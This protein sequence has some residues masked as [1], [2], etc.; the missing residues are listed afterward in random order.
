LAQRD[1]AQVLADARDT[2]DRIRQIADAG[3][4]P[5]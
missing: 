1:P 2:A 4:A 5:T 3:A